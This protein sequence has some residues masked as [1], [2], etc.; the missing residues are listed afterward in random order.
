MSAQYPGTPGGP[1]PGPPAGPPGGPPAG[2]TPT[3]AAPTGGSGISWK[4]IAI[5]LLVV[6]VALGTVIAV[7]VATSGD[8]EAAA[9]DVELEP[10]S[11]TGDNPFM[12]SVGTDEADVT[13]PTGTGR[14]FTGSTPGLYGGTMN[15]SSCDATQL[16]TYLQQNP[17]KAQAWAD[18]IG[19]TTVNISTYVDSLTPVVL[20]SD[21]SVTNHGYVNGRATTIPAVLQAGT[22]VLVDQYGFPVVKCYCGNPL[23][24]PRVYVDPVYIGTPWRGF[25]PTNITIIQKTTV[26]I[27]TFVL[28]DPR[29]GESFRRPAGTDGT[30][31]TP[32]AP[33]STTTTTTLPVQPPT[34]TTTQ[35]AG[36]TPEERAAAKV[37][38]AAQQCY[39]F[40]SPIE[41]S[42]S[43]SKSFESGSLPD[44]FI[45]QVTTNTVDGGQQVFR[46]E[47]SANTLAFTPIND[48]AQVASNHCPLL[49]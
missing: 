38:Q 20:R 12:A 43:S 47:V 36:P 30:Q 2:P 8:D 5:V 24:R 49:N 22:A 7:V 1:P 33:P 34:S 9:A 23:T 17:D 3:G 48:L 10:I 6:L 40:P 42:T 11:S 29:T 45:I 14:T 13:P 4:T 28:V 15:N 19:I 25:T 46:W 27:D 16:V 31:D 35:P 18:V 32:T 26:I 37:D 44:T 21:V 39:P 41:D